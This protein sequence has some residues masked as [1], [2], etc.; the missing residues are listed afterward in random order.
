MQKTQ[1]QKA[2]TDEIDK[3]IKRL[4]N[5]SILI[6]PEIK[7]TIL[8]ALPTK[9]R[10]QKEELIFLLESEKDELAAHIK[11][12]LRSDPEETQ[13]TLK[14]ITKKGKRILNKSIEKSERQK[15]EQDLGKLMN[16]LEKS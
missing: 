13:K 9:N 4:L 15:E 5:R 10:K 11:D 2:Q 12:A 7:K 3:K 14:N 8:V 6:S 1:T 16:N